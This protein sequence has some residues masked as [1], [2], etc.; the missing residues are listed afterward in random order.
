LFLK[1]WYSDLVNEE[2]SKLV[3]HLKVFKMTGVCDTVFTDMLRAGMM[4]YTVEGAKLRRTPTKN[5][6]DSRRP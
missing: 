2:Q 1:V 6:G 3:Q 5:L 4:D